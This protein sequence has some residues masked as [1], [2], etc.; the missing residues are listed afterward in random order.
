MLT[1]R[2]NRVSE[3]ER[4]AVICVSVL[5]KRIKNKAVS[6]RKERR[7][8]KLYLP[9]AKRLHRPLPLS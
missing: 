1:A 7:C 6:M 3:S 8:W 9:R 5:R 2:L 4:P